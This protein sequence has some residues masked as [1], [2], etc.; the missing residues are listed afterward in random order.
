MRFLW[1]LFVL[2]PLVC[3][4]QNERITEIRDVAVDSFP[5]IRGKLWVRNPSGVETSEIVFSELQEIVNVQFSEPQK[6]IPK[7][8]KSIVFLI[9]NHWNFPMPSQFYKDV[10]RQALQLGLMNNG[11]ECAVIGYDCLRPPYGN[12]KQLLFP[13]TLEFHTSSDAVLDQLIQLKRPEKISGNQC[14]EDAQMYSAI[15][16]TIELLAKYKTNHQKGLVVLAKDRSIVS[17]IDASGVGDFALKHGIPVYGI[18]YK[19]GYH[20]KF[21]ARVVCER[22]YGDYWMSSSMRNEPSI[23]AT[24][25]LRF[26]SDFLTKS[27]G[28]EYDFRFTTKT[29]KDGVQHTVNVKTP[30][31]EA[32]F[33]YNAPSKTWGE[34]VNDHLILIF[35]G[36]AFIISLFVLLIFIV[37]KRKKEKRIAEAEL[38]NT[39]K[40]LEEQ[41]AAAKR[42][43]AETDAKIRYIEEKEQ[44]HL[45]ALEEQKIKQQEEQ[46]NQRLIAEMLQRGAFAFLSYGMNTES[47]RFQISLPLIKIGRNPTNH[48]HISHATVSREHATIRFVNGGYYLKDLG[49][50]N[51]TFINGNRITE[52]KLN[53]GDHIAF[54]DIGMTFHI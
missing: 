5:V 41:K 1:I 9:E 7:A 10:V 33:T 22:S 24:A 3:P 46:D 29:P 54:G 28:R 45:R 48:F 38:K 43:Q 21:G 8:N 16:Q 2:I 53:D 12:K 30:F 23:A 35:L 32:D 52:E 31:G 19:A 42:A 49:S 34:R 37:Q 39:Q 40:D 11:D 17:E 51:G 26:M 36:I 50:S 13:N 47:G 20:G 44:A 14:V 27:A 4:S 18:M 6:A 15:Y 25:L